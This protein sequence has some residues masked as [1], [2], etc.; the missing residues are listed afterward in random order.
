MRVHG[1]QN[2][3]DLTMLGNTLLRQTDKYTETKSPSSHDVRDSHQHHS[4]KQDEPIQGKPILDSPDAA[5]IVQDAEC[6]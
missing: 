4:V 3:F 6:S 2:R 1:R 5:Q